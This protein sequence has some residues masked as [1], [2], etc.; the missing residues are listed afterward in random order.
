MRPFIFFGSSRL[1]VVVLDEL[2]KL[3]L[4]PCLTVTTPD[5]PQGRKLTMTPNVVKQWA[6]QHEI[7]VIDPAKLDQTV[8]ESISNAIASANVKVGVVASYGKIIPSAT[9]KLFSSGLLNIHPSLLPKYRGP[10]PL[11]QSMLDDAKDTGVTIMLVDAEMDHGSIVAQKHI[12]VNEWPTYEVFEETMA[13]EGAE[14]LA[15]VL[16]EWVAGTIIAHDQ[17]HASATYTKKMTKE[18]GLLDLTADP[19]LN[20]RKI[21][22]YHQWPQAYFIQEFKGRT[23]RVKVTSASFSAGKLNIE[24]VVPEGSKEMK[25]ADFLRGYGDNH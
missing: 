16:P 8:L 3:G 9:L 21:Q 20:Y 15:S 19:Y 14:L 13:R 24:K 22:A 5:K 18:D 11:P 25:Y 4:K 23:I 17:D 2:F 6:Q 12:H 10:A 1:S 7:A